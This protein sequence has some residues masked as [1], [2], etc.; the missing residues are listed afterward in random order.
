MTTPVEVVARRRR[1]RQSLIELARRF[2]DDL[3]AALEVCA[4]VVVGSAARGDFN[5]WSDVDVLVIANRLPGDALERLRALGDQPA[6]VEAI[7]WTPWEWQ[8]QRARRNPVA[9]EA[10]KRGVWLVGEPGSL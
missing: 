3:D 7:A 1:E 2:A 6:R 9:V 8:V 4:V 5:A 10:E